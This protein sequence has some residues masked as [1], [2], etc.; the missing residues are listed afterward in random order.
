MYDIIIGNLDVY[1]LLLL[2]VLVRKEGSLVRERTVTKD[3]LR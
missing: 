2:E 3:R 1:H